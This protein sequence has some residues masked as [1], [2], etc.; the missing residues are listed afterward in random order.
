MINAQ[1]SH[2]LQ[3]TIEKLDGG[4]ISDVE[5][6]RRIYRSFSDIEDAIDLKEV[7][8]KLEDNEY[9]LCISIMPKG[10]II[11]QPEQEEEIEDDGLS[12]LERAKK[13]GIIKPADT[14]SPY[15]VTTKEEDNVIRV[16]LKTAYSIDKLRK[17]NW[18]DL[19]SRL[20]LSMAEKALISGMKHSSI[21][22]VWG[23]AVSGKF[24]FQSSVSRIGMTI[25][26]QYY[27]K[28]LGSTAP[29]IKERDE[30]LIEALLA[31]IKELESLNNHGTGW[32]KA[33]II[34]NSVAKMRKL[35]I[36]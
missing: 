29:I 33:S 14:F 36:Q 25:L 30:K 28:Q 18:G 11:Q 22:S 1:V 7:I 21:Y 23:K 2:T 8:N 17:I 26:A 13:N 24:Q 12:L 4:F 31:E 16:T 19:D 5:Q 15:P 34:T 6:K 10:E 27:E 32:T 35:L 20:S 3:L 9:N